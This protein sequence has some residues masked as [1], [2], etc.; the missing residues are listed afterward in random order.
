MS[1][2]TKI[3]VSCFPKIAA[4]PALKGLQPSLS[5]IFKRI[6]SPPRIIHDST[7]GTRVITPLSRDEYQRVVD[8]NYRNLKCPGS[9]TEVVIDGDDRPERDA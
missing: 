7:Y 8:L 1:F 4:P 2:I 5:G 6:L 9:Y 3:A